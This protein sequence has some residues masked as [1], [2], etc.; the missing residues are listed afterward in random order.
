MKISV[1]GAG[2]WGTALAKILCDNGHSVTLWGHDSGH[3]ATLQSSRRNERHLPG[4]DLPECLAF[5]TDLAASA[6]DREMLVIAVPSGAVRSITEA[7]G[8]FAGP[9]VS[10]TKG[11][12]HATGLT[13]CGILQKTMPS[14]V[15]AGLSGPSLALETIRGVPTAIVAASEE[16][17]IARLV[18]QTFHRPTFRVYRS[19]DLRGVELGG[20]LKNVIA[21]GAGVCDGLG[22]GDNSKAALIT[23]AIAEIRRLGV[24]CGA[25]GETFSGLSGLG[26]LT[27]TCFSKLSRNR[28]FG[29]RIGRGE[30]AADL[31]TSAGHVVEGHPTARSAWKLARELRVETPIIDA[32]HALLHEGKPLREAISDLIQREATDEG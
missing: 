5:S 26:D 14:A 17:S 11:I 4:C 7:L 32:V 3:I 28:T 21:I 1:I 15:P 31:L 12:E 23:R 27:V 29:E 10:V 13:M 30:N 6:R 9:A 2:A 18:Q 25:Q 8:D 22:F 24:A 16:E 20:A 19:T